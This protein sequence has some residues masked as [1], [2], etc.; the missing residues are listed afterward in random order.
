MKNEIDN[1]I[2]MIRHVRWAILASFCCC[3][4][5]I[6]LFYDDVYVDFFSVAAGRVVRR[7]SHRLQNCQLQVR[8]HPDLEDEDYEY[9]QERH[10][11]VSILRGLVRMMNTYF[12]YPFQKL[13]VAEIK[14]FTVLSELISKI[15]SSA[16]QISAKKWNNILRRQTMCHSLQPRG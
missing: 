4:I 6:R 5:L 11:G 12:L 9:E 8:F 16:P 14:W 3:C 2:T 13:T 7:R 10:D 1:S 15:N